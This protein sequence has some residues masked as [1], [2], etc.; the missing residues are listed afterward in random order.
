MNQSWRLQCGTV[1]DQRIAGV[2]S[3]PIEISF[4]CENKRFAGNAGC[5]RIFGSFDAGLPSGEAKLKFEDVGM[6][7]MACPEPLMQIE[8]QFV[9]A[10]NGVTRMAVT[11]DGKHLILSGEGGTEMWFTLS[12]AQ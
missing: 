2:D 12:D 6:T 9:R 11:D 10:L 3:S 8:Q 4:D 7:R 5:N 1:N